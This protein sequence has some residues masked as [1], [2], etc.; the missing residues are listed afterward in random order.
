VLTTAD[1]ALIA[2]GLSSCDHDYVTLSGLAGEPYVRHRQLCYFDGTTV[3]VVGF[4]LDAGA[5]DRELH[6]RLERVIDEWAAN[7]AVQYIS[8]YGPV[9][10]EGPRVGAWT[11]Q[12][13]DDPFPWNLDVF[14][15]LTRPLLPHK[16]LR[17]DVRRGLRNGIAVTV[18]RREYLTHE[19]IRLMSALAAR[20]DMTAADA[21]TLTNLP[22]ILRAP[23]SMV[24][25][26]RRGGELV[27]FAVAH[28]YFDAAAMVVGAAFDRE[29]RGSSDAIYAALLT[30]FRDIG[31]ARLG[32]GYSTDEKLFRYKTK[33]GTPIVGR[34][35]FQRIWASP[36]TLEDLDCHYWPWLLL[37]GHRTWTL[38]F[39]Y[40][41]PTSPGVALLTR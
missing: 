3:E 28:G 11:C 33:W 40:H 18:A 31:F 34:P 10:L 7:P 27:G 23:A 22:A 24:F 36:P 9:P 30:Y 32:F 26:A 8:Y 6:C 41:P 14:I 15:D 4:P 35:F 1:E 17:Q 5:P 21:C 13:T 16:K 25:E 29:C 37:R 20:P 38:P 12:Y 39:D 2:S 19:H